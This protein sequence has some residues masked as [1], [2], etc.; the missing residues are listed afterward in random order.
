MLLYPG[1]TRNI[2]RGVA[3]TNILGET[4]YNNISD[5]RPYAISVLP[6]PT[7]NDLGN[8]SFTVYPSYSHIDK[9]E[10]IMN[11]TVVHHYVFNANEIKLRNVFLSCSLFV[12][13]VIALRILS[14]YWPHATL[15]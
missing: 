11:K 4:G 2:R 12:S 8:K 1:E 13:K 3:E 6:Y 5:K 7:I 14:T 15:M 10:K 9:V